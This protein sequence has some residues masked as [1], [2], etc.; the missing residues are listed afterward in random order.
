MRE[1]KL[2][3][4]HMAAGVGILI[5]GGLHMLIMHFDNTIGAFN[6]AGGSALDWANVLAR[7]QQTFF[8]VTYILLLGVTLW[9]GLYGLRT[10]IFELGPSPALQQTINVMFLLGGLGLLIIGSWAA[11][12]A[13]ALEAA[14]P[15]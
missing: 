9:H 2:W 13:K 1:T 10:I 4:W 15:A 5:L 14:P 12:A 3:T 8:V 7:A 11:I 6:P